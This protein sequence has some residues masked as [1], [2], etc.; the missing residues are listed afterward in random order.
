[1]VTSFL[2]ATVPTYPIQMRDMS[3]MIHGENLRN[4]PDDRLNLAKIVILLTYLG[5]YVGTYLLTYILTNSKG[6]VNKV[7]KVTFQY[8]YRNLLIINCRYTHKQK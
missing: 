6:K 5:M 1:M 2:L 4:N 8:I 7:K 3:A